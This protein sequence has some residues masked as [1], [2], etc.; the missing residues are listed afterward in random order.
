L[1]MPRKLSREFRLAG[2][3]LQLAPTF[4]HFLGHSFSDIFLPAQM[5]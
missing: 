4:P 3:I 5:L 1:L 2:A